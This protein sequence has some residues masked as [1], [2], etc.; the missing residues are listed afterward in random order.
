MGGVRTVL[1]L[2]C[3]LVPSLSLYNVLLFVCDDLRP[4]LGA[5]GK[6]FMHTP[7]MDKF[8]S[9]SLVF[10]RA[11]TNFAICSPSRNSFMTGR[12]PD[13]TRVWNFRQDFRQAG[14]GPTGLAG[15]KWVTM[16]QYF[17]QHSYLTLGHGKLYHPGKPPQW[18]EPKSWSQLQPY[19]PEYV[20]GCKDKTQY[21]PETR[22]PN[23]FSD[24]N[25]T[26]EAISTLGT[27]QAWS[28]ANGT[29]FFLGVG[30]HFPHQP[31][32]T[33]AR[34]AWE[35]PP[36]SQ[37]TLP[38]N[39]F[40]PQGGVDVAFTA[41]LDGF[42]NLTLNFENPALGNF[43]RDP[44][45]PS[46]A[47]SLQAFRVPSPG[48]QTVPPYFQ[49]YLRLGYYTAVSSSDEKFGAMMAA[50][51]A[52]GLANT[53]IVALL[54]DHGWQLGEHSLWGKHTNFD[55]SVHVPLIIRVPWKP[56]SV[57]ARTQSVVELLDLYRTLASL[58]GLPPPPE[59][60]EGKDFSALFDAPATV[61]NEEAY[62]QY[63]R[64][65]GE[66]DW[67]SVYP[68]QDWAMN[69]C[70]S[71]PVQNI[72]YMVRKPFFFYIPPFLHC[73]HTHTHTHTI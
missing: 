58:A 54:G 53:T 72:T 14:I 73:S 34:L 65:P 1:A 4:Q 69:N 66:R 60:V 62:A 32:N 46:N 22:D 49:Q 29:N 33:E 47:T 71:V 3:L 68:L 41:E 24:Y 20:V 37:L 6:E 55:T 12:Q 7:N 35:Y 40:S 9:Q 64:C 25:T 23:T 31:W 17:K 28:A 50:L 15:D 48:N 43:S 63:S 10:D 13:H 21:C 52:S 67:P 5:Y 26:I 11:Y 42:D 51:E 30:M 38:G 45:L 27:M 8:A 61:L 18:D 70:E 44:G 16:P 57:G 56:H 19:G 39:P 36:G 2:A 59:D